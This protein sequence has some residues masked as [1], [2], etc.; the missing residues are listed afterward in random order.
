[1]GTNTLPDL[2]NRVLWG[3]DYALDF[4]AAG[5]PN[6]KATWFM[7]NYG[8]TGMMSTSGAVVSY[9]AGKGAER[10]DQANHVAVYFDASRSNSIYGSSNT[11]QPPAVTVRWFIQ[12]K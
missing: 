10:G 2:R 6:I 3:S 12:A 11:V 1:M 7:Y 9:F 8:E 5:L 4:I